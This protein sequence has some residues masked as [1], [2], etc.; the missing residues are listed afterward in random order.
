MTV[1]VGVGVV[2]SE[3]LP[4]L[5]DSELLTHGGGSF[6]LRVLPDYFPQPTGSILHP[7]LIELSLYTYIYVKSQHQ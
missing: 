5:H 1:V 3:K 4:C 7:S 6:N 2:C